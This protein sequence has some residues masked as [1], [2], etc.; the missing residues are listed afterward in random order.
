L[1]RGK[2]GHPVRVLLPPVVATDLRNVPPGKDTHPAYFF[3]SGNGHKKSAVADWQRVYRRVFKKAGMFNDPLTGEAKRAHPHMFR[4]TFAIETLNSGAPIEQVSMLLGHKNI[5]TTQD[6]Y[7]P[8]VKSRQVLLD[9]TIRNS[10]SGS[11]KSAPNIPDSKSIG[12]CA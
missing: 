5:K 4:D 10:W 6:S 1:Y 11:P 2:T 9:A 12:R 8:W 7:L 3:W